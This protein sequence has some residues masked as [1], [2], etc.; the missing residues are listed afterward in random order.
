MIGSALRGAERTRAEFSVPDDFEVGA[1]FAIGHP[2]G[3]IEPPAGRK[4]KG[5]DEIVFSG[6]WGTPAGLE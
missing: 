1:A 3:H 6:A 5:L 4:R 2:E